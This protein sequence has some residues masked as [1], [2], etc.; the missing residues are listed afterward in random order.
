MAKL[1]NYRVEWQDGTVQYF[2]FDD[3]D[4]KIFEAAAK[5]KSNA[6]K[7]IKPG[8]PEPIN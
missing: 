3:D 1:Q 7:S 2:Q 4:L 8:D 6:V 5:N